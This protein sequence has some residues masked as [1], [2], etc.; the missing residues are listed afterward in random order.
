MPAHLGV[1][2]HYESSSLAR[3]QRKFIEA[4]RSEARS[5]AR[6]DEQHTAGAALARTHVLAPD[7]AAADVEPSWR[8]LFFASS[9]AAAKAVMGAQALPD[10]P[11]KAMELEAAQNTARRV[12][13]RWKRQPDGLPTLDRLEK[14]R[15]LRERGVTLINDL[16][17]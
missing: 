3:W 4:A 8:G 5:E 17:S 13:E 9:L 7:S 16:A 6:S 10:T 1:M 12:W 15:V 14:Y 11:N 2:L